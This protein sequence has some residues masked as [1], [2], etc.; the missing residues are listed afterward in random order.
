MTEYRA[1]IVYAFENKLDGKTEYKLGTGND[2]RIYDEKRFRYEVLGV[3][4]VEKGTR[5]P[6]KSSR[7]E[8]EETLE[9]VAEG[10]RLFEEPM[11]P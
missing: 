2:Q 8:L 11:K 4:L 3:A 6:P 9:D 10:V 1:R 7:Q 5:F